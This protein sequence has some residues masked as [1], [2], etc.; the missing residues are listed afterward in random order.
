VA[1]DGIGATPLQTISP[2]LQGDIMAVKAP[3]CTI[4]YGDNL[5]C[6]Q[7]NEPSIIE[8]FLYE[9]DHMLIHAKKG[10]GKSVTAMEIMSAVTTGRPFLNIYPVNKICNVCWL[11]GESTHIK[12]DERIRN[13][14]RAVAIDDSR[15]AFVNCKRL[16]L[17]DNRDLEALMQTIKKTEIKYDLFIIDS[18]Y[19]FVTGSKNSDEIA[20]RWIGNV[21]YM[22][23]E[24]G[25]SCI[26]LGHTGK[27]SYFQVQGD[28]E[29]VGKG[30]S[31]KGAVEWDAAFTTIYE[32]K[33]VD[34]IAHILRLINHKDRDGSCTPEITFRMITP[35]SD[36]N[37]RLTMVVDDDKCDNNQS[38]IMRLLR[39]SDK[40]MTSHEICDMLTMGMSSFY[41]AIDHCL[42]TNTIEKSKDEFGRPVYRYIM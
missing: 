36:A 42:K 23:D 32:L 20:Q 18:L 38:K 24:Y 39:G 25:A 15:R 16:A 11:Q 5:Y 33:E 8:G 12:Y 10:V 1:P 37:G 22:L 26:S 6:E 27:D 19:N 21:D 29:I 28:K 41:Y 9:G 17:N 30:D 4:H 34:K 2:T 3:R 7:R 13:M 40:P 14:K 31:A 35:Q